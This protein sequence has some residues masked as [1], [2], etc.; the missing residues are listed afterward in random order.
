LRFFT[1]IPSSYRKSNRDKTPLKLH[2]IPSQWVKASRSDEF[3]HSIAKHL[4][5]FVEGGLVV[6]KPRATADQTMIN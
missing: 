3:P 4:L 5:G 2:R 6:P 1:G